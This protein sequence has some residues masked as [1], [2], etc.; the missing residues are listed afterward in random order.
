MVAD[1][2]SNRPKEEFQTQVTPALKEVTSADWITEATPLRLSAAEKF[3]LETSCA[4]PSIDKWNEPLV[5]AVKL[6]SNYW[7]GVSWAHLSNPLT[8]LLAQ[9]PM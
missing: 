7:S 8:A 1:L 9:R 4:V 5:I 3:R 6:V 2:I